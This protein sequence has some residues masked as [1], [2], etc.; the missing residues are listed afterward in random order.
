MLPA[1]L[2]A[3]QDPREELLL[4]P[5]YAVTRLMHRNGLRAI[6]VDVWEIHEA[7]AGQVLANLAAMESDRFLSESVRL[8][9]T[10]GSKVGRGG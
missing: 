1:P 2:P 9:G 10:G 5:A 4:G 7:F 6:D 3:V 8:P